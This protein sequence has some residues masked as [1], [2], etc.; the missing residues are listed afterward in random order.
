MM[1]KDT[2]SSKWVEMENHAKKNAVSQERFKIC[3]VLSVA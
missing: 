2:C 3:I 1:H